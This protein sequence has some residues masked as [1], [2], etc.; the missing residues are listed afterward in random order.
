VNI[1][2]VLIIRFSSIGDIVLTTP[3]IRCIKNQLSG[4]EVHFVTKQVFSPLLANN[5]YVDKLH[6]FKKDVPEVYS[7]L[8]AENFDL[9]IDLHKNL[10]SLRLKRMLKVRSVSFNKINIQKFF[11]VR[12]KMRGILPKVHIVERYMKTVQS[13]G[14]NNDGAGLDCFISP[15]DEA[16][17][18]S[19]VK[20]IGPFIALVVGGSYYTK[21]I[22]VNKLREIIKNASLPVVLMGGPED[23]KIAS[24]LCSEFKDLINACGKYSI[25]QSA[26]LIKQASWVITSDTGLMHIA[27]AFNKRIVSVWGNTIPEFGMDPYM[28]HPENKVLEIND[29]PCRPC[30]K[31]GYDQ[32]PLGHFKCM[33]EISV[34]LVS[35]L[36]STQEPASRS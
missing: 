6:L 15:A 20:E 7:Q 26:A 32:C 27:S 2:K 30:S 14:I 31:L 21:K 23:E 24:Q 25:M 4:V 11:A 29:L 34:G 9:V 28:P 10:R 3:L 35:E 8:K 19:F 22:P 33:N 5:P 12:F 13:L 36:R 1:K 16:A 18:S 17:V